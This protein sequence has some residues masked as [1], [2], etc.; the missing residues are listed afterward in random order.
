MLITEY[1]N[2]LENTN[3]NQS[4]VTIIND[5]YKCTLPIE[6][7]KIIT[8]NE[9]SIFLDNECRI[10]SFQEIVDANSDL[11]VD[12]IKQ[13]LLPIADC[14][15]NDFLVYDYKNNVWCMYNIID[16]LIFDKNID[17]NKLF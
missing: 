6:I 16:E 9:K 11:H 14:Y 15:D 13:M 8:N 12:F 17:L 4:K 2:S 1:V 5:T 10:L 3:I 7:Q